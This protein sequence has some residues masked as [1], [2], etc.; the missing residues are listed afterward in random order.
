MITLYELIKNKEYLNSLGVEYRG[1]RA[2][3]KNCIEESTSVGGFNIFSFCFYGNSGDLL[4]ETEITET[5]SKT[6]EL[7]LNGEMNINGRT[8]SFFRID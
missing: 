7:E 1:E 2:Y 5:E 4:M 6:M 3:L 8:V